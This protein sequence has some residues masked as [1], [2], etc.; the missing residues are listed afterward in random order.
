MPF[1]ARWLKPTAI[2]GNNPY[3]CRPIY[4][5]AN[6]TEKIQGFSPKKL[7]ANSPKKINNKKHPPIGGPKN[8]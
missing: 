8:N 5:A 6:D 2:N 7:S 1:I 4:G 3:H